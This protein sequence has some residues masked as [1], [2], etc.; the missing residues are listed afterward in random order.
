MRKVLGEEDAAKRKPRTIRDRVNDLQ[1]K[2]YIQG[3]QIFATQYTTMHKCAETN[4][5]SGLNHFLRTE[6]VDA[7]DRWGNTCLH[8]ACE[9]GFLEFV[10]RLL[11][12]D[13][14]PLARNNKGWTA[15]HAACVGGHAK[16]F[17]ALY[18]TGLSVRERDN[19]GAT[20]AHYAAQADNAELLATIHRCQ[21]RPKV[22]LEGG[23]ADRSGAARATT[24]SSFAS[25]ASS[26]SG[27]GT[28][29]T[30]DDDDDETDDGWPDKDDDFGRKG[31]YCT[32]FC[33]CP[34]YD[35]RPAGV[36]EGAHLPP[37]PIA[38]A[39]ATAAWDALDVLERT[40]RELRNQLDVAK[41]T[42]AVEVQARKRKEV[43]FE[44]RK[45]KKQGRT[46][47]R[48]RKEE[49]KLIKKRAKHQKAY[50]KNEA[51]EKRIADADFDVAAAHKFATAVEADARAAELRARALLDEAMKPDGPQLD[52]LEGKMNNGNSPVHVAALFDSAH[53]LE[54]LRQVGC[55]LE[56]RCKS[57]ETPLGKAARAQAVR[58]YKF[59]LE[60]GT[61]HAEIE[62]RNCE[63]DNARALVVDNTRHWH[64]SGGA[65]VKYTK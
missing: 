5:L 13:A 28:G 54:Y 24:A 21:P 35:F 9:K 51:R 52:V 27:G 44:T 46:D 1:H 42:L 17:R 8:L 38:R 45:I 56:P 11:D 57:G 33:G 59:L 62:D 19:T 20:P 10:E 39:A 50:A 65:S 53:A 34:G 43:D 30:G 36:D 64:I 58:A 26:R 6:D 29:T 63:D 47:A 40:A 7:Q 48:M 18:E 2:Q 16:A 60:H 22:V 41:Q 4:N 32:D 55:D 3:A 49:E 61:P 12:H 37:A 25:R 23:D 14:D 31:R 15:A